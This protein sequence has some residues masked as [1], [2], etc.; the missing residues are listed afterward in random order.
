MPNVQLSAKSTDAA[1]VATDY[2][3]VVKASGA[4]VRAL[5]SAIPWLA[6][7]TG[8]TQRTLYAKLQE[9]EVSILDFG[10]DPTGV[11]P[12]D[13]ALTNALA[14]GSKNI[15]FPTGIYRFNSTIVIDRSVRIY[16]DGRNSTFLRSYVSGGAHGMQIVGESAL[17]RS[18]LIYL[19][20]F[21]FE[22]KGAGQT[23]DTNWC[24]VFIQRKVHMDDVYVHGFTN[25][26]GMFAPSNADVAT[27]AKGT[28]SNAP[29]FCY[30]KN[31]W[32]KDNGRDGFW[33][34]M[35]ANANTF[36]NCQFDRNG[37]YGFRHFNDS[38]DDAAATASTYGNTLKSGQASYNKQYGFFFENGT[39]ILTDALYAECNGSTDNT[40]TNKYV[41]TPYDFYLGDNCVRSWIGIGVLFAASLTHVRVPAVNSNTIQ[42]WEGGRK[43]FGDT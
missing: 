2:I 3:A 15:H 32:F 5:F 8:A 38:P 10:G 7:G 21:D 27:N 40:D 17:G 9:I 4:V 36:E 37:R 43:I 24:G 11:S 1:P 31:V 33:C 12:C 42:V 30:L 18:N 20:R 22:Y 6:S 13:A 41:N 29:F 39:N 35:G 16:G 28:I 25:D 19:E 14:S 23:A 26:G 34:R